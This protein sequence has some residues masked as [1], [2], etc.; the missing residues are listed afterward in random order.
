MPSESVETKVLVEKVFDSFKQIS[1][2]L[3]AVTIAS[4]LILFL[5]ESVLEKMALNNLQDIWKIVIGLLFIVSCT[6]IITIAVVEVCSRMRQKIEL[7]RF[8]RLKRKQFVDLPSTYKSMLVHLLKS[9]K[10]AVELDPSSG[11]TLYLLSNQF[12]HQAQSYMFVGVDHIAP[13]TYVPEP[14]LIDLFH[15]EPDLFNL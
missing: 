15:K 14:W 8:R 11:N 6:L 2:A 9:P 7:R 1:P 3:I 4:G 5:P 12:I 13:V 10:C